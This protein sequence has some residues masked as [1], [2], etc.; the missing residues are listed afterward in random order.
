MCFNRKISFAETP[1]LCPDLFEDVLDPIEKVTCSFDTIWGLLKTL[2][3]GDT[4]LVPSTTYFSLASRAV[5]ARS[6]RYAAEN[7]FKACQ[8]K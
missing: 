1:T 5:S 2:Y 4:K 7:I 6:A 3:L 8:V